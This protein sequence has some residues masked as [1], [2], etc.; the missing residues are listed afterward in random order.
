MKAKAYSWTNGQWK[1]VGDVAGTSHPKKQ[2]E[3]DKFFPKGEYDYIFDIQDDSGLNRRLPFNDGENPLVCAEKFL[4]R[5]GM[6]AEYKQQI[7]Q[8]IMKNAR[9]GGKIGKPK[10]A[11]EPKKFR[12]QPLR[13]RKFFRKMNL[14]GLQNKIHEL[15]KA[16]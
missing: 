7:V 16:L 10:P 3:G 8:F 9:G 2:Y 4:V 11:S 1:L 6:N 14:E 15:N 13:E 5:E 12:L